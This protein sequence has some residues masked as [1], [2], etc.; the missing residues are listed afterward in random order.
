MP[1]A[2]RLLIQVLASLTPGRCGVSD[3]AAL[4]ARGVKEQFGIESAFVVLNSTEPSGV[5]YPV[6]H[7]EPSQLLENCLKLSGGQSGAMLVH[8]SGYG[9]A[10]DGAPVHLAEALQ[11]VKASRQFGIAAYFHE[12]IASGPPWTS[13]FWHSRRQQ[14]AL[15]RIIVQADLILTS[16]RLY[17]AWLEGELRKL[18]GASIQ[19][20]PVISSAGETDDPV[21]FARRQATMLVFGLA[22]NRKHSYQKLAE[23]GYLLSALGVQKLL[24]IGPE[25]GHPTEVNGIPVK[26]MGL[27]PAEELPAVFSQSQFGIVSTPWMYLGKSSVFA[28]YCAQGT[29]PVLGGP[30]PDQTDGLMDGVQVVTSRSV[31]AVRQAGFESCSRAA[32]NWYRGHRL[33]VHAEFY[34][35]WMGERC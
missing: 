33:S 14:K 30:F 29:I 18:G 13:A 9:Y 7:C 27:L 16:T 5:P 3:Q 24:D 35:K 22:G 10:A 23:A 28:A 32:W 6:I 26:R 25:C 4:L 17:A 15:G 12:T 2:S 20:M 8:V 19:L 34:A 21:P 11:T 1:N 31:E